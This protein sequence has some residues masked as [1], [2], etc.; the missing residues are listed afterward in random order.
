MEITKTLSK[1][2]DNINDKQK[3]VFRVTKTAFLY[4]SLKFLV[5]LGLTITLKELPRLCKILHSDHRINV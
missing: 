2:Q 4:S 5:P 1:F 3:F